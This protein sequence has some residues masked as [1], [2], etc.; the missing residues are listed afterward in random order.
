MDSGG[1]AFKVAIFALIALALYYFYKWLNGTGELSDVIIYSSATDGLPGYDTKSTTY[2]PSN[3]D[4]PMLFSGGEY[5][6]STWVYITDWGVNK[7]KNKHLL[8]LSGGGNTYFTTVIYLGQNIPKVGIRTSVSDGSAGS[9]GLNLT[10]TTLDLIIK[11]TTGSG[12]SSLPS[13]PYTDSDADLIKCDIESIDIQRW[14]NITVVMSG[15]TQDVYINGKMSRS[16]VLDSIF[17]VD[18][19]KP[20][21]LL[22]GPGGFGGLIGTTRAANFAYSPD[23][24]Y[25]NYQNGP[26]DTSLWTKIKSY[27]DIGQYSFTLQKN[28]SN[29]VS[30]SN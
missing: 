2:T 13:S 7:N 18:G 19:D 6:I 21:I 27:F 15:R 5:S 20:T 28:G 9:A 1:I 25:K 22:G 4:I 11:P 12:S 24:V 3:S 30:A 17:K 14:V 23:Q 10:P 26:L 8:S 16:C 29:I